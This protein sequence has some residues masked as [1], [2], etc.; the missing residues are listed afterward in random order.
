MLPAKKRRVN[1][2]FFGIAL[3]AGITCLGS[4]TGV[5]LHIAKLAPELA[6]LCVE[7]LYH[8]H[9]HLICLHH[10]LHNGLHIRHHILHHLLHTR[11]THTRRIIMY[12]LKELAAQ[13]VHCTES[14]C[15]RFLIFH[16]L[17]TLLCFI[18]KKDIVLDLIKD[19]L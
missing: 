11:H 14:G 13:F 5:L 10:I 18:I 3:V 8:L 15:V 17:I 12:Q 19:F 6:V 4:L 16:F 9:Y 7:L 2:F 1:H